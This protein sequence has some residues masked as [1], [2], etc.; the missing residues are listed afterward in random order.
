MGGHRL[1][2][3]EQ[4]NQRSDERGRIELRHLREYGATTNTLARLSRSSIGWT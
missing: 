4:V 1:F 2:W 3:N